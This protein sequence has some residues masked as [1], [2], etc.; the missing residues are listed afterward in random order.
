MPRQIPIVAAA[1]LAAMTLAAGWP[2]RSFAACDYPDVARVLE[3]E[4]KL[5]GIK[6]AL[7]PAGATSK[8]FVAA[9]ADALSNL[10]ATEGGL[11]QSVAIESSGDDASVES[12]FVADQGKYNAFVVIDGEFMNGG[13]AKYNNALDFYRNKTLRSHTIMIIDRYLSASQSAAFVQVSDRPG[14][15]NTALMIE[16]AAAVTAHPGLGQ[17]GEFLRYAALIN[18]YAAKA[19]DNPQRPSADEV[20]KSRRE[21]M[22]ECV[23]AS[24]Q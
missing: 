18:D 9:T 11:I 1:T 4:L 7:L 23:G 12:K 14:A 2:S 3:G 24:E 5:G 13:N 16:V 17:S 21:M 6:I 10:R 8:D 22:T 19:A 15:E 20:E